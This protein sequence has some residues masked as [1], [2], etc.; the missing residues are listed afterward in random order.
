MARFA[1]RLLPRQ[2]ELGGDRAIEAL[3]AALPRGEP[4][5]LARTALR[6]GIFAMPVSLIALLLV[7]GGRME[8]APS[9]AALA[10]GLLLALAAIVAGG[11]ALIQ[12]WRRGSHGAGRAVLAIL[13]GLLVLAVPGAAAVLVIDLP[14]I[15]DI[16]TDPD[17]PPAFTGA[18]AQR[19]PGENPAGYLREDTIG[20]QDAAYPEIEPLMLDFPP[21][22][23]YAAATA[24]VGDWGWTVLDAGVA[25]G[26]NGVA[27]IQARGK[28]LILG[29]PQD[30]AI[31]IRPDGD[32]ARVDMRSANRVG[33]HDLG[34][35]AR[36]TE[37]FLRELGQRIN[38]RGGDEG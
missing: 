13:C 38:G 25:P 27:L 6:I 11:A 23:V 37:T 15:H 3:I 9:L 30:I 28:S 19:A 34:W 22:D 4:S 16:T 10:A 14:A 7:R 18:A 36:R 33:R 12:I 17:D 24:L 31:R 29:L 21:D 26:E 1:F 5:A 20:Q 8:L 2:P 35:N 32:G